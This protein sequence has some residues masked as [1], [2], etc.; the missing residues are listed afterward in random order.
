MPLFPGGSVVKNS[1][2]SARDA[3]DMSSIPGSVRY[4]GGY[5]NPLQYYCLEKSHGQ[6]SLECYSPW[7]HKEW[8]KTELIS[9]HHPA[10]PLLDI[11]PEKNMIC[12]DTCTPRFIT[13][14]FT[15][16]K[17]WKQPKCPLTE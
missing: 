6:N 17:T 7:D 2:A 14:L 3:G 15:I 9:M 5:S 13:T 1:S 4:P 11:Y 16:A 8:D 10:I 12:K